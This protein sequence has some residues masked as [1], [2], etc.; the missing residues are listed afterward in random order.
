M[1]DILLTPLGSECSPNSKFSVA[2]QTTQDGPEFSHENRPAS[3]RNATG[4]VHLRRI[5]CPIAHQQQWSRE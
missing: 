5:N 1:P 4:T 3:V 2:I